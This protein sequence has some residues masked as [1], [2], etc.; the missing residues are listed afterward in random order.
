MVRLNDVTLVQV[1]DMRKLEGPRG[2]PRV[3]EALRVG[4][5]TITAA[6]DVGLAI[7]AR[8]TKQGLPVFGRG[9][10]GQRSTFSIEAKDV[11]LAVHIATTIAVSSPSVRMRL[12]SQPQSVQ[13]TGLSVQV[14]DD[15]AV[16][17][18]KVEL[19]ATKGIGVAIAPV[20]FDPRVPIELKLGVPIAD[21]AVLFERLSIKP[22]A[23]T[24]GQCGI[25]ITLEGTALTSEE[26]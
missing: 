16:A 9:S 13:L 2:Q 15:G 25:R 11:Y 26:K 20:E 5:A 3:Y 8:A 14:S 4:S 24:S 12:R 21:N 7:E 23:V 6:R 1:K 10:S 18:E 19:S 17:C 22:D